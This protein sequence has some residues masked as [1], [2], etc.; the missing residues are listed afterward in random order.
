MDQFYALVLPE[1]LK[2]MDA[3][4]VLAQQHK[5][6]FTYKFKAKRR[7]DGQI[8]CLESYAIF[9]YDDEGIPIQLIGA[10]KDIT[11]IEE[12]I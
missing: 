6:S 7:G 9:I 3:Q 10:M 2:G 12:L 4:S 8:R 5:K 1:Y 11:E